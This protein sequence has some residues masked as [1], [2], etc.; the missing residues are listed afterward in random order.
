MMITQ[1]VYS[2]ALLFRCPCYS[3]RNRAMHTGRQKHKQ[4]QITP[5]STFTHI[6]Y[7]QAALFSPSPTQCRWGQSRRLRARVSIQSRYIRASCNPRTVGDITA[8]GDHRLSE[9]VPE[10]FADLLVVRVGVH[11]VVPLRQR[12]GGLL[13]AAVLDPGNVSAGV[14]GCSVTLRGAP[15]GIMRYAQLIRASL[16]K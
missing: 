2:S 15:A 10:H 8:R 4:K 13:V 16:E 7:S 6:I 3:N 12:V 9:R 11:S 14:A 1:S 5:Q